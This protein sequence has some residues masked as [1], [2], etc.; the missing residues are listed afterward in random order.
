M[1]FNVRKNTEKFGATIN[2][3]QKTQTFWNTTLKS[4]KED[5]SRKTLTYGNPNLYQPRFLQLIFVTAF[6]VSGVQ[7]MRGVFH[8]DILSICWFRVI[9]VL[10][11][12]LHSLHRWR[13][14]GVRDKWSRYTTTDTTG[15]IF[16]HD[17]DIRLFHWWISLLIKRKTSGL[18]N[19]LLKRQIIRD[20]EL[21]NV[22]L[23]EVC[24]M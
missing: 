24:C 4:E 9:S 8:L 22:G 23:K 20:S 11:Y 18:R 6:C 10:F 17:L 1:K 3:S 13:C 2:K 14:W 19:T 21:Q 15:G 12:V 7:L 5:I 16:E